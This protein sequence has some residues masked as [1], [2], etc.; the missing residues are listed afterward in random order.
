MTNGVGKPRVEIGL[1]GR[2]KLGG[3]DADVETRLMSRRMKGG[4]G[5]EG[6]KVHWSEKKLED[7][8][9]RDWR[10]FREDFSISARGEFSYFSSLS[11]SISSETDVTEFSSE[12]QVVIFHYL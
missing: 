3:F 8:K 10:I 2:G 12:I 11:L 6:A 1:F 9:E 5:G 4:A 7:M